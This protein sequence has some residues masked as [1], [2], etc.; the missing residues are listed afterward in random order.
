[1]DPSKVANML[2]RLYHKF[3]TL[4]QEL[5]IFKVE[6]IGDAYMAVTNLVTKQTHD[7]AKRIAEFAI[8]AVAVANETLVREYTR[9]VS[10]GPSRGQ[11]RW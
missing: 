10:L 5:E 2:D 8:R 6:T 7:H 11:C 9:W 3:D 4:S 1:M